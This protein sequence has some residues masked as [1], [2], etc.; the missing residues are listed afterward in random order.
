MAYLSVCC[1]FHQNAIFYLVIFDGSLDGVFRQHRAVDFNGRQR[2]FFHNIHVVY[3]HG[4]VQRFAL[5]PFGGQGRRG[6]GGATTKGFEFG[7]ADDTAG[8][9]HFD[10]E[11]HD[12]AAFGRA[13]QSGTDVFGFFVKGTHVAGVFEVFEDFV[14]VCHCFKIYFDELKK[15]IWFAFR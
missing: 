6:D 13:H 7:V 3:A 11:A 5:E 10:L 4:F 1:F 12:V 14:A 9:I 2:Q 8:F 15:R